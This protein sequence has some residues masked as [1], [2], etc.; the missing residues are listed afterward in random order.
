MAPHYTLCSVRV[1]LKEYDE[2]ISFMVLIGLY[3][4]LVY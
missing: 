1:Y 2:I 3:L 4:L